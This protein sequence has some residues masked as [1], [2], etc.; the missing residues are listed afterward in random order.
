MD[1]AMRDVDKLLQM[2]S[3]GPPGGGAGRYYVARY[4]MG[5]TS[6]VLP[7]LYRLPSTA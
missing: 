6:L 5:S 2:V 7:A 1:K 3:N 4:E